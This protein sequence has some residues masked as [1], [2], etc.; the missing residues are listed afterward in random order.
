LGNSNSTNLA[1]DHIQC[2]GGTGT[3]AA[4]SVAYN[5]LKKLNQGGALN[6]ILLETDGLPNTLAMN[7]WDNSGTKTGISSNSGCTDINGNSRPTLS[8]AWNTAA[9]QRNWFD[10]TSY[11]GTSYST[12]YGTGTYY[13]APTG[14]YGSFY[15]SDPYQGQYYL[16]LFVPWATSDSANPTTLNGTANGCGFN[17]SSG[18]TPGSAMDVAWFPKTDIFGNQLN[19]PTCSQGATGP[20]AY[21]NSTYGAPATV[22]GGYIDVTGQG[23]TAANWSSAKSAVL[24]AVDNAAYNIRSDATLKPVIYSI[25][26]AG[27]YGNP[28]D[29]TLLQRV[30]NDPFGDVFNATPQYYSCNDTVHNPQCIT[31]AGQ[32]Q[33][34]FVYSSNSGSL[35]QAF[36]TLSGQMLRL[37]Q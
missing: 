9:K 24:N 14:P 37:S 10:T 22:T 25:G 23:S 35:R 28:P 16:D 21:N 4:M 29:T 8:T 12:V 6:V 27:N 3:T 11:T 32:Q 1:I 13:N 18:I 26:L 31:F 34:R 36:L 33:G 5:E 17:S 7:W 19:P 15:T 30:A 20:C 2:D